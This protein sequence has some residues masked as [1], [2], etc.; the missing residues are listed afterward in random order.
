MHGLICCLV[1]S[2]HVFLAEGLVSPKSEPP[3]TKALAPQWGLVQTVFSGLLLVFMEEPG[4]NS[5]V[6]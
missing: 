3:L 1:S 5:K 2:V 4:Q 6:A